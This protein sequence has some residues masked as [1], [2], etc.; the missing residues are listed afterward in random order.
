MHNKTTRFLTVSLILVSV[1][2]IIVF[3]FLA[4]Y[5]NG[6]SLDTISRVGTIYMSGMSEQM[7]GILKPPS[8]CGFPSRKHW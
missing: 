7:S 2:C 5:M 4:I 8:N 6:Q 3:S 1:L